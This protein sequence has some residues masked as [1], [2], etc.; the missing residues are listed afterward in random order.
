MDSSP[1]LT[2]PY[3]VAA[4][5]QKHVTH[6]EAIR[7]LD[8]LV[9]LMVLDKDLA[10]PPGSPADG[11]RYIVAASPTGA[12][13]GQAGKVA[14][15]QDGAWA[16]FTP[17]R[18]LARLGRRRGQ[19][20]RPQRHG[21]GRADR[22]PGQRRRDLGHQCHRR[23]HQP[24]GRQEHGQPL[25]Q[26][27]Q[28]PSAEDQQERRRRYGEH[29][30]PDQLL[31]PR[32]VRPRRRRRFSRQGECGRL[33][34]EGSARHR[35]LHGRR[36][37]SSYRP[38]RRPAGP[39]HAG[40]RH[41]GAD[42]RPD[43]QDD[44]LLHA[45]R[46]IGG[47][48]LGRDELDAGQPRRALARARQQL[49]SHRLPPVGQEL[50]P[51]SRLQRRRAAAGE[52]AGLD[53]RHDARLR[54]RPPERRLAQRRLDDGALRHQQRRHGDDCCEPGH[55]GRDVSRLGRRPNGVCA[56]RHRRRA[57]RRRGCC[58]GTP[59]IVCRSASS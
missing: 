55:L 37:P 6:N 5:A 15:Y 43:R 52:R 53:Q 28:R 20:L 58:F 22:Q 10:S 54:H 16:F 46:W 3:I 39:P 47:A 29:A 12:W 59:T 57:V 13:A 32:R 4:Q 1:N 2:L 50:R 44:D 38:D 14:A 19:G 42:L 26:R 36:A 24:P 48:V 31:R 25:R 11:N 49:G 45:L 51:L 23:H 17:A 7:A 33:D 21:V 56:R 9:Q 18:G 34:V 35:S 41:A 27:R 40:E 30:L 8:A